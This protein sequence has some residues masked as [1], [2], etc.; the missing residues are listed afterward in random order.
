MTDT[1]ER[2]AWRDIES[3]PKDKPILLRGDGIFHGVE[4]V[5]EWRKA[6]YDWQTD[7]WYIV[8]ENRV[9]LHPTVTHWMPRTA[10]PEPQP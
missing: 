10:P 2:A 3:A 9:I 7:G 6:E 4:F 5:G 8:I 1:V